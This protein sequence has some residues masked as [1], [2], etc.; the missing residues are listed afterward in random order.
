VYK[1]RNKYGNRRITVDGETF[2]SL[3]EYH[4]YCELQLLQRSGK[5]MDLRRQVP[6][7][8]LPSY[9]HPTTGKTVR[10]VKYVADFVYLDLQTMKRVIED[11]KGTRTQVYKLKK[12]LVEYIYQEEIVEV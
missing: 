3:K 11:V 6:F 5:I 7:E 10:G 1:R 2:D 9:K 4:R 12:K 8:I